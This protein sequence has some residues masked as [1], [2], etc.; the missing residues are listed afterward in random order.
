MIA[1]LKLLRRRLLMQWRKLRYGLKDVHYTCYIA[2]NVSVERD[3]IM[4]EYSFLNEGCVINLNVDIGRYVMFGPRVAIVGGDHLYD[5]P[6]TPCI[7]SGR[8]K[9]PKTTIEDDAWIGYGAI[10]MSGVKIGRGAIIAAGSVVTRDV[11][12]YEIHGGV[13]NKKIKMRFNESEIRIHNELLDGPTVTGEFCP[14][15][16]ESDKR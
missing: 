13:P 4:R 9:V 16:N 1:K 2:A 12:P 14:A 3:L 5:I 6:G 10:V 11:P 15:K 8:D 7:F